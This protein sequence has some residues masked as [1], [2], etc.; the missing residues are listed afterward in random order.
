MK[1]N[2]EL[3]NYKRGSIVTDKT[4]SKLLTIRQI[5]DCKS[6]TRHSDLS[7]YLYS[8]TTGLEPT[9]ESFIVQIDPGNGI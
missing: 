5:W 7:K 6:H 9:K 2:L 3:F 4:I 8:I 1:F